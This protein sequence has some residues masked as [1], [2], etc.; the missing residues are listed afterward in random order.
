[1]PYILVK[2]KPVFLHADLWN[3]IREQALAHKDPKFRI[4]SMIQGHAEAKEADRLIRQYINA[5][6]K[7]DPASFE[8]RFVQFDLV[9]NS[10][11][12][13]TWDILYDYCDLFK[14]GWLSDMRDAMSS[15]L[16][17]YLGNS[18]AYPQGKSFMLVLGVHP[19]GLFSRIL[20]LKCKP[21][22]NIVIDCSSVLRMSGSLSCF[23]L[24]LTQIELDCS[25]G[26][27]TVLPAS[28]DKG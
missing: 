12:E 28:R 15:M 14:C 8:S 22:T 17:D 3:Q 5:Q 4:S 27:V 13:N 1:M 21:I 16:D 9:G 20:P 24:T 6:Y 11:Q 7:N 19:V 2:D 10:A 18:Y 25:N 23:R 26:Q